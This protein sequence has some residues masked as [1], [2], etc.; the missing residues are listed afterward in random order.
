MSSSASTPAGGACLNNLYPIGTMWVGTT[1]GGDP[2][3]FKDLELYRQY[4]E[5]TGCPD[6]SAPVVPQKEKQQVTPFTGFMEFKPQDPYQQS[7]YS[8]MSPYWVGAE[9]EKQLPS[10]SVSR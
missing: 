7:L 10:S 4:N 2:M 8:A 3:Q 1:R 9:R 6:V 5:R